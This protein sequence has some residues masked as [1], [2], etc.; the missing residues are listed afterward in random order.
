MK[1]KINIIVFCMIFVA[2]SLQA[3]N[4][5]HKLLKTNNKN[6]FSL[7]HPLSVTAPI[8]VLNILPPTFYTDNIGFFCKKEWQLEKAVKV[9]FKFRLGSIQQVDYLEGKP[10]SNNTNR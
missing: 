3:Q 10:N 1:I 6:I 7:L 5:G 8:P 4:I 9:P 2:T